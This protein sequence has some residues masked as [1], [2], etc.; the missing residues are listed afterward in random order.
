MTTFFLLLVGHAL[1]DFPLQGDYLARAKD[2]TKPLPGTPWAIALLAH[3]LIHAGA[4]YVVTQSMRCA[5]AELVSHAVIDWLKCNGDVCYVGDQAA[6][7]T[8][9]G[10]YAWS[11]A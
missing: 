6:H 10:F 4:V 5:L 1:A 8:M 9:K 11:L 2:H 3:A 7:V